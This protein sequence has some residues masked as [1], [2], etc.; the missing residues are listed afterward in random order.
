MPGP[1]TGRTRN[2]QAPIGR[3]RRWFLALLIALVARVPAWGASPSTDQVL[4]WNAHTTHAIQA[5]PMDPFMATRALALESIA[6]LDT[7]RSIAGAPSFLVHLTAPAEVNADLA[8][9]A[10]A[11]TMLAYL[12]P[13]RRTNLA[14]SYSLVEAAYPAGPKRDRAV[15]FGR[16]IA[17]AI[18]A[19][20]DQDGWNAIDIIRSG[21]EPGRWRPTPR[22]FYPP[23]HPHWAGVT[24]FTLTAANQFRPSGPP[25]PSTAAFNAAALETATIGAADSATRTADQTQAAHY[26]NDGIGTYAPAGHWNV[27]AREA[28][29]PRPRDPRAEAEV[30]VRLNVAIADSAIAMADTKY[31]YWAW[32]P[33]TAIQAGGPDFPG[34]PNWRSLLE[35]PNHPGY[36]SG[37]SV[38]S[39]AAATV[40]TAELGAHPFRTGSVGLPG[41]F[42]GFTHFHHAAE[43]AANSRLWGGI[44]FRFDNTDGLVIGR[45]AGAWVMEAFARASNDRGPVIVLDEDAKAGF[46][47]H[48]IAPIESVAIDLAYGTRVAAPVDAAGRFVMPPVAHGTAVKLSA[49]SAGGRT[50]TLSLAGQ[51]ARVRSTICSTPCFAVSK[52]PAIQSDR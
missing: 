5:T 2:S 20:R 50:A 37:H 12:F 51:A 27:I 25:A 3:G 30:L 9:A 34:R 38:F 36:V 39:G 15:A 13:T 29:A 45:A 6:V 35:T 1:A 10:S 43:E 40:L 11:H 52:A 8:V 31:T 46:V 7:L 17:R 41:V 19:I 26:W 44:H 14:A 23:L 18:I 24:P 4:A 48:H 32:R 28:L 16:S 49:T 42:R 21:S 47:L 22:G 33:L